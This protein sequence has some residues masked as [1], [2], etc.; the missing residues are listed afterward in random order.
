MSGASMTCGSLVLAGT[1]WASACW[2]GEVIAPAWPQ[3]RGPNR[4]GVAPHSPRLLEQW[5]KEGP[6]LL[7][8]SDWI[9]GAEEGGCGHPVVADG[10]VFIYANAKNP[11]NGGPGFQLITTEILL[12]AG[13]HESL[14]DELC[15]KIEAAWASDQRPLSEWKWYLPAGEKE[16]VSPEDWLKGKPELDKYIKDFIATLTA[17]EA[18]K[19]GDFI[20]RRLCIDRPNNKWGRVNGISWEVLQKL[21]KLRETVC[22]SRR[23]WNEVLRK[24]SPDA[25]SFSE[26]YPQYYFWKRAY[27]MSDTMVALDAATGKT[28]WKKEFPEDPEVARNKGTVQWWVF[29]SLGAS[30]TPAYWEGRCYISGALGLYCFDAKDGTQVWHVHGEPVHSQV[31]VAEGVVY[32]GGRGSAYDARTGAPV[33]KHPLWPQGRWPVKDDAYRWSPPLIWEQ[34][35]KTRLIASDGGIG[36]YCCLEMKTGKMLWS[37]KLPI[38]TFPVLHEDLLVTP[39]PYASSGTHAFRMSAGGAELLWK[40]NFGSGWGDLIHRGYLYQLDR[41][42]NLQTG[43]ICWK[44]KT[45]TDTISPMIVADD[46]VISLHGSSHQITKK[47]GGGYAVVMFK[48]TPEAYVELGRFDPHACHM[49]SPAFHDG[50]LYV[51]LLDGIACYDLR[52]HGVVL[53]KAAALRDELRFRFGQTGGG[54]ADPGGGL[55]QVLLKEGQG[56]AKPAKS[57]IEGSE[58]VVDVKAAA[59]P[60]EVA[61]A[62]GKGL[63]GKNGAPVPAFDWSQARAFKLRSCFEDRI[64]LSS[65]A[66]LLPGGGWDRP[67]TFMAEG[68]RINR[69]EIQPDCRSLTLITDKK[70]QAGE[71]VSLSYASYPA[72]AGEPR[73]QTLTF[74]VAQPLAPMAQFLKIDETTSGNWKGVYGSEGAHVVDDTNSVVPAYA[75]ITPRNVA[76]GMPWAPN[77]ADTKFL[78]KSGASTERSVRSWISGD[79][80]LLDFS[81]TDGKPHQVAVYLYDVGKNSQLS[82]EMLHPVTREIL[83]E[84]KLLGHARGKYMLWNVQGEVT[85]SVS[86]LVQAEGT[87]VAIGGVFFDPPSQASAAQTGEAGTGQAQT[88]ATSGK[89]VRNWPGFR[90]LDYAG[91]AP[92]N[93]V[94][95][96]FDLK[97]GAHVLWK[98]AIE[99]GTGS[100]VVW[101]EKVFVAGSDGKT[102]VLHCFETGGGKELWKQTLAAPA[103]VPPVNLETGPAAPTPVT[104]G[105]RIYVIYASGNAAAFDFAGKQVWF[106]NLGPLTT[107]YGY[108]SSPVI[109]AG[110][111]VLQL[112]LGDKTS[113]SLLALDGATGKLVW[114][115]ERDIDHSWSTPA[116]VR[117]GGRELIV[118]AAMPKAIAYDAKDG[119]EVWTAQGLTTDAASSPVCVS[120]KAILVQNGSQLSA[121]PLDAQGEAQPAWSTA[122]EMPDVSSPVTDG[123]RIFLIGTSGLLQCFGVE[124][125]KKLWERDLGQTFFSS[126]T[127]AGEKLILFTHGENSTMVVVPL[128]TRDAPMRK[129]EL[130]EACVSSPAIQ[131]GRL[132]IRGEKHLLCIGAGK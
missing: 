98:V 19:Y 111:L 44:S 22:R 119:T 23:E 73:R 75:V 90:G 71:Q 109:A 36:A 6:P 118:T 14:P 94:P 38:G 78:L 67:E 115:K 30:S 66:P 88:P 80:V 76:P 129:S 10:K 83:D 13:W 62:G 104:D 17:E 95:D 61:Y 122:G 93:S 43:S 51:R 2:A 31:V 110:R 70:W 102:D 81:F 116:V 54:L 123:Q 4:N 25:V 26:N 124:R 35:G 89:P 58:I 59:V 15:R 32:D 79:E 33:W 97:T 18:Q 84:R 12:K 117:H 126:P 86:C 21:G 105:Q 113:S 48:A 101:E 55:G 63:A 1:L 9:P 47:W 92:Q 99:K 11:V 45:G 52:D 77:P 87:S 125:G 100:P 39:P 24:V 7:W 46:K 107:E 82:V 50:R 69:V 53:E 91:A 28:L 106:R 5:P 42:V 85:L 103:E 8:K 37:V 60:F 40:R 128:S 132:Y 96:G 74:A 64:V 68:A 127:L 16:A 20:R 108:A 34:E 72:D 65:D 121:V 112:D 3:W 120:G 49:T 57:R 29:D 41:C 131:E 130:L 27:T 114:Q 56:P